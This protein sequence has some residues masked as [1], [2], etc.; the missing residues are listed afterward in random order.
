MSEGDTSTPTSL[1]AMLFTGW[2][3]ADR[4]LRGNE[5]NE[6]PISAQRNVYGGPAVLAPT[7]T[8]TRT[9]SGVEKAS[10]AEVVLQKEATGDVSD[11]L[12]KDLD[13]DDC[14]SQEI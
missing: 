1:S 11:G 2:S 12:L 3:A 10:D 4:R 13:F 14:L 5:H 8:A 7:S 9:T 6:L